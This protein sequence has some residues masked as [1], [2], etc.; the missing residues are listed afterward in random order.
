MEKANNHKNVRKG[1]YR[2]QQLV[3]VQ[4]CNTSGMQLS[5]FTAVADIYKFVWNVLKSGVK[6]AQTAIG[7]TE[8]IFLW[9]TSSDVYWP[10]EYYYSLVK[11]KDH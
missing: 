6:F 9:I 5:P 3:H 11:L 2:A 10:E 7:K 8:R 1:L 4:H